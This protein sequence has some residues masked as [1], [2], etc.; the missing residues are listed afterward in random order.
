ME[1]LSGRMECLSSEVE[2]RGFVAARKTR[3]TIVTT[4]FPST[5]KTPALTLNQLQRIESHALGSAPAHPF[6]L[7]GDGACPWQPAVMLFER[8]SHFNSLCIPGIL[9]GL[10]RSFSRRRM[11]LTAPIETKIGLFVNGGLSK[12]L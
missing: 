11:S 1:C 4:M 2:E 5:R 8:M 9:S 10:R 3:V 12:S 6:S 7:I